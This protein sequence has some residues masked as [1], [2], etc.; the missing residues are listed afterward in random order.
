VTAHQVVLSTRRLSRLHIRL[1]WATVA[2]VTALVAPAQARPDAASALGQSAPT[3]TLASPTAESL[4]IGA[5]T[6]EATVSP[7]EQ[8]VRLEF[9]VD[10]VL[11]CVATA[12]PL[13]CNWDAGP[14]V[15]AR[16]VRA[17]A[18]L[19]DGPRLTQTVRTSSLDHRLE[20]V[21]VKAVLV[22]AVVTDGRGRFVQGLGRADFS[23]LENER[24]VTVGLFEAE[25]APLAVVLTVDLSSSMRRVLPDVRDAIRRF[26]AALKPADRVTVLGFNERMYVLA[27]GARDEVLRGPGLERLSAGGTT[28]LYDAIVHAVGRRAGGAGRHAVVVVSDGADMASQAEFAAVER[29]VQ[30]SDATVYTIT[31]GPGAKNRRVRTIMETLAEKSGGRSFA[32][33]GVRDVVEWLTFVRDDLAHQYLLGYTPGPGPDARRIRVVAGGGRYRVRTRSGYQPVGAVSDALPVR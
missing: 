16:T 21:D 33:D 6:F 4:L 7:P 26:V 24:P 31:V 10:G 23:L 28:A 8:L 15:R 2:L 1:G 27:D 13:R 20:T 17:V 30:A 9:F 19:R 11:A 25:D 5:S 18:T 22:P 3:L 32:G 29:L 14:G 12:P